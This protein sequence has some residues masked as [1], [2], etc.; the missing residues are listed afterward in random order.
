MRQIF[1]IFDVETGGLDCTKS[2][3]TQFACMFLN[4]KFEVIT[5]FS[6]LI[7]PYKENIEQKAL[8]YSHLTLEKIKEDGV[9]HFEL[10]EILLDLLKESVIGRKKPILCGHNV[11]FDISFLKELFKINKVKLSD[12]VQSSNGEIATVDTMFLSSLYFDHTF[13][14]RE[15]GSH[16]LTEVCKRIGF[17]IENAHNAEFDVPATYK[18]LKF[19]MSKKY[20][21]VKDDDKPKESVRFEF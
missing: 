20:E 11:G 16:S 17:D 1:V 4:S 7:K 18:V 5:E 9:E 10:F 19:F 2:P 8:E 15:K 12:F 6:T 21:N 3:I 13:D 14:E